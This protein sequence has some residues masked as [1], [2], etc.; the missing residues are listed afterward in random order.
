MASR[1]ATAP[2]V[3]LDDYRRARTRSAQPQSQSTQTAPTIPMAPAVW[4][5]WVPVWVW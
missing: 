2:I 5:Y 3:S 4:V 1:A